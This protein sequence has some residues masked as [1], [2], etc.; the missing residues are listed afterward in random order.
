MRW[1]RGSPQSLSFDVYP[2][3]PLGVVGGGPHLALSLSSTLFSHGRSHTQKLSSLNIGSSVTINGTPAMSFISPMSSLPPS[4]E[5]QLTSSPLPSEEQQ[6][7]KQPAPAS[8]RSHHC[9]EQ[10]P[11]EE[12]PPTEEQLL[13]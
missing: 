12:M 1:G 8:Q 13:L 10:R 6:L 2:A 4:E 7:P 3:L 11:S 9:C 5:Q